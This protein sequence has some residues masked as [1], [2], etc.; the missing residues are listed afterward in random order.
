V[1]DFELQERDSLDEQGAWSKVTG[2]VVVQAGGRKSDMVSFVLGNDGSGTD[3]LFAPG[4]CGRPGASRQNGHYYFQ[5]EGKEVFKFAVR[6]LA[7]CARQVTDKAGL[8]ITDIDL[9]IPHQANTRINEAAIKA[10]AIKSGGFWKKFP[11]WF[12][13]I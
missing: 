11:L 10:M 5:M 4:P 13:Q 7:S 8:D 2:A 6:T 12:S 3:K 1:N 9:L